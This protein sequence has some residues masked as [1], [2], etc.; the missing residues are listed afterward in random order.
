M[1][2]STRSDLIQIDAAAYAGRDWEAPERLA[3]AA[4][5]RQPVEQKVA[6]AI[7][8]YEA[9]RATHPGWPDDATRRADLDSHRA[10]RAL[11]DKAAHVGRR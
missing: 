11:L 7:A 8:L 9:A 6:L 5:A 10:L 4:R 3:R 1:P 2:S